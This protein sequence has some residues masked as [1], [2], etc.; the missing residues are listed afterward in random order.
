MA[1]KPFTDYLNQGMNNTNKEAG[2]IN[3]PPNPINNTPLNNNP[4]DVPM[5]P[6]EQPKQ[7]SMLDK[8]VMNNKITRNSLNTNPNQPGYV[9]PPGFNPVEEGGTNTTPGDIVIPGFNPPAPIKPNLKE[10]LI[11]STEAVP[12]YNPFQPGLGF[13]KPQQ[14]D[15]S[16]KGLGIQT[17]QPFGPLKQYPDK[18]LLKPDNNFQ[19]KPNQNVFKPGEKESFMD[20]SQQFIQPKPFYDIGKVLKPT[21]SLKPDDGLEEFIPPGPGPIGQLSPLQEFLQMNSYLDVNNDGELSVQDL[22]VLSG[23]NQINPEQESILRNFILGNINASDLMSYEGGFT[24]IGPE[25]GGTNTIP[26]D[27]VTEDMN[28]VDAPSEP[29]VSPP[30]LDFSQPVFNNPSSV[31]PN[32]DLFPTPVTNVENL[33]QAGTTVEDFNNMASNFNFDFNNSGDLSVEDL[34][35]YIN[36]AAQSGGNIDQD[37]INYLKEV[38]FQTEVPSNFIGATQP[39]SDFAGGGG[40][41]GQ[42]ARQLY[43]PSTTGGFASAGSGIT[44]GQSNLQNLLSQLGG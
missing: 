3:T 4:F 38:L 44:G 32:F 24:E 33:I 15:K 8:M 26:G 34:A 17:E 5:S 30:N 40:M 37:V 16:M 10:N 14:L 23:N 6:V 2:N 35:T 18:P 21:D 13:D 9:Q 12:G 28:I 41:G 31:I 39:L 19:L 22:A 1:I 29:N 25:E 36:L 42:L 43:Y 11:D 7:Q 20:T 27:I